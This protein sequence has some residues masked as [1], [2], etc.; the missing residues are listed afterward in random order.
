MNAFEKSFTTSMLSKGFT[1]KMNWKVFYKIAL[2]RASIQ[3]T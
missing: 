1:T 2:E 3:D